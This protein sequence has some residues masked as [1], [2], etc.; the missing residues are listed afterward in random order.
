MN[1]QVHEFWGRILST[2]RTPSTIVSSK[3]KILVALRRMST[4][5]QIEFTTVQGRSIPTGL[6]FQGNIQYRDL[7]R[8]IRRQ[9]NTQIFWHE[10][11]G[12]SETCTLGEPVY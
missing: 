1:A 4:E 9:R 5:G 11:T 10:L 8:S 2:L 7:K 6:L 3:D 12:G